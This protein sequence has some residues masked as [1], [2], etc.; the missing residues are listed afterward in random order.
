MIVD[1]LLHICKDHPGLINW[2]NDIWKS[3]DK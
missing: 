3:K 2:V 1:R